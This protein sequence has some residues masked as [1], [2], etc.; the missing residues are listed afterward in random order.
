MRGRKG[1]QVPR[2]VL[3][4]TSK[5]D[6]SRKRCIGVRLGWLRALADR[7]E[8]KGKVRSTRWRGVWQEGQ[9]GASGEWAERLEW[10]VAARLQGAR[11]ATRGRVTVMQP[12]EPDLGQ[13]RVGV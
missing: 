2:V 6:T 13:G 4:C 3:G 8:Y 7:R 12:E 10:G 11:I 9:P 5:C 1:K